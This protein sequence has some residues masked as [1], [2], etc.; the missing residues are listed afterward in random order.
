MHRR[1]HG[2]SAGITPEPFAS[3]TWSTVGDPLLETINDPIS[4]CPHVCIHVQIQHARPKAALA[5]DAVFLAV[6]LLGSVP[7]STTNDD[8]LTFAGHH[9]VAALLGIFNV[10]VLHNLV[11]LLFGVAG[12]VLART[13]NSARSYLTGEAWC[14]WCSS[15][16]A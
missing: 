3:S 1:L 14:I 13:F 7:G 9:F 4:S 10:S 12:I 8:Q 5:V 11:H 15:S 2:D 16:P 6:G